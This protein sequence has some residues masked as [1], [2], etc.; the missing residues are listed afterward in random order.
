MDKYIKNIDEAPNGTKKGLRM[1][2]QGLDLDEDGYIIRIYVEYSLLNCR[3]GAV[4]P[5]A[6][7]N[8]VKLDV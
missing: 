6:A 8:R 5:L 7:Y 4:L 3:G 1:K 2:I